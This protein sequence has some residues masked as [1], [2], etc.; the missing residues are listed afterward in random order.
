MKN[1]RWFFLG[2]LILAFSAQAAVAQSFRVRSLAEQLERQAGDLAESSYTDY[3]NSSF[4][5]RSEI[6]ALYLAQQFSG[7]AI[8]FH[9]MVRDGRREAEL[10]DAVAILSELARRSD[11][12][13]AQRGRWSSVLRTLD[14]ILRELNLGSIPGPVGPGRIEDG[15]RQTGRLRWRGTV[16]DDVHLVI[17]NDNVEVRTIGG[18]EYGNATYNFT[19]ALPRRRVTVNVVR[20]KGR[21][22][23]RVIQQPSRDNDFSAVIQIRDPSGGARE[24]EIEVTW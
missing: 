9:R 5:N 21:G 12:G 16:D 22:D 18:S 8:V 6:E 23:V 17:R 24:Y 7:S 13:F 20:L 2:M 4:S 3:R 19:S 10:R 1:Y 11:R 15:G 14:D